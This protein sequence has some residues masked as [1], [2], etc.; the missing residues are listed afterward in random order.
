MMGENRVA[1]RSRTTRP[2]EAD[3]NR[4]PAA[5]PE[6]FQPVTTRRAWRPHAIPL[7]VL[8]GLALL[9]YANS[10]R[11]GLVLDNNAIIGQDTRIRQATAENVRLI[12]N[13]S[14]W[15]R[16]GVSSL[17]RPLTTF[18]YLFNY[19][20]LRNGAA[21]AGYHWVNFVLH[22][23]NIALV[24]LLG[25]LLLKERWPAF[26][27]AALWAV[28]PVLTESVTNIVGRADLLAAFGVLAG[29][30]CYAGSVAAAGRRAGWWRLALM[31]ATAI[32]VFSKESG[33]VAVAVVFLYDI[34]FCRT[35]PRQSRLWGYAAVAL[36]VAAFLTV[37]GAV[38]ARL[39]A[40]HPL[41]TD[42]PLWGADFFTSR[43]TAIK[44]VGKYLWLLL[45]PSRL[46][47]DYSY[48]QIPLFSW[49]L[50]NWEDWKAIVALA[51]CAGLAAA[52]VVCYRRAKPLL[53]LIGFFFLALAPTANLV[54]LIGTIMA[55]RLL[56]L[57]SVGF[58]GCLAWLGWA[59]YRRLR[60]RWP[61]AR[62]V[63]PAALG[64]VCLAFCG[65]TLARNADWLDMQS[66][67]SSA[68][69]SCPDSYKVHLHVALVLLDKPGGLEAGRGEIERAL[70]IQER[71][72]DAQ[73]VPSLY[74]IA[75]FCYRARANQLGQ[76]GGAAWY[77]KALDTLLEGQRLDQAAYRDS[78]LLSSLRGMT[79]PLSGEPVV[80]LELGR[81]YLAMGEPQKALETL[82]YGR[83]IDPR[84]EFFEEM[85]AAYQA[86]GDPVPAAITLLEG[87]TIGEGRQARLAAEV[88]NLYRQTAPDSCALAGSGSSATI[89]FNCP[90][91]HSELCTAGRNAAALY[92]RM[93]RESEAV[94]TAAS[95][96]RSLGCPVEMFR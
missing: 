49:R 94:A 28:H 22:A 74:A 11:A 51:V 55:E 35:M 67:W 57:P 6:A 26:A 85:A 25:L 27:M 75:G 30:L 72:P 86:M 68:E 44:V 71:L 87:I 40:G 19:A 93:L 73:K 56:Y 41:F 91:V 96:V 16:T 88:V 48:N 37:R 9:A 83:S 76:N 14:Y 4:P 64:L 23:V 69:R 70:A 54:I 82:E 46:S 84:P 53:F 95:A 63:A 66:V 8:W 92:R 36:P 61:A 21:T 13:Q 62:I 89:D 45:W 60:A 47:S 59:G 32:A 79:L 81:T 24:Y 7:L 17:Y 33:V 42:N 2:R 65:R 1:H 31:A 78:L 18:S 80:Y 10:F 29:L 15:Y 34:T 58:A 12:L 39:P 90:L 50:D 3:Y 77:R 38:L 43:L 5:A 20:I 52:A